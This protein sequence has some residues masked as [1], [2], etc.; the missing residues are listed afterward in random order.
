M[1][2]TVSVQEEASAS[3][4]QRRAVLLQQLRQHL[5]RYDFGE[6]LPQ[7][8]VLA[9]ALDVSVPSLSA[10]MAELGTAGEVVYRG[11]VGRGHSYRLRPGEQHPDDAA[12]EKATRKAIQDGN[13]RP[14]TPLP[15]G[16]LALRHNLDSAQI[17]RACRGLIAERLVAFR[18]DERL[19]PGYYVLPPRERPSGQKTEMEERTGDRP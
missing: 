14:G 18:Q 15:L 10:A 7:N 16:V 4:V 6:K 1:T 8:N 12:F 13:Y 3:H 17:P 11:R 19:G 2:G 5:Q 9:R